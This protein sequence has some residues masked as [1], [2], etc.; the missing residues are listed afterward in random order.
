MAVIRKHGKPVWNEVNLPILGTDSLSTGAMYSLSRD[1]APPWMRKVPFITAAWL[2]LQGGETVTSTSALSTGNI[3][4]TVIVE[5]QHPEGAPLRYDRFLY[6]RIEGGRMF[7]A[8]PDKQVE[9]GHHPPRRP[10]ELNTLSTNST[11]TGW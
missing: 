10:E 11:S 7:Q 8:G 2:S 5:R 6:V 3:H 9:F 1:Q 4:A